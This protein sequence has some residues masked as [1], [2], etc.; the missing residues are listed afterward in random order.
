MDSEKP[1][2][3]R[4]SGE[5][6]MEEHC[7]FQNDDGKVHLHAMPDSVT[8][9]NGKQIAPGQGYKLRSGYRIILGM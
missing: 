6:I 5:N 3:I 7:Y 2:A 9:L 8:F 4:L 1:A